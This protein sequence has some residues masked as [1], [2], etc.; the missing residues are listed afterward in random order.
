MAG[1]IRVT[2]EVKSPVQSYTLDQEYERV[3]IQLEPRA[4]TPLGEIPEGIVTK[5]WRDRTKKFVEQLDDMQV[6]AF[7]TNTNVV[8]NENNRT[9]RITI[10][11]K[12]QAWEHSIPCGYNRQE[13]IV[14]T[15]SN[16]LQCIWSDCEWLSR[17]EI[18]LLSPQRIARTVTSDNSWEGKGKKGPRYPYLE[19]SE[20]ISSDDT[21]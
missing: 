2:E 14:Y 6:W 7:H 10:R 11:M 13:S 8:W 18:H 5:E 15:I 1:V 20:S 21:I 16:R 12:Q 9:A 17:F 4:S 19:S 3:I